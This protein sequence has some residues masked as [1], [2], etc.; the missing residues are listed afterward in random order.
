MIEGAVG[1]MLATRK[2]A[3]EAPAGTGKTEQIALI[4]GTV[5]GRWLVLTHTVA[6]VDAIRKRLKKY[7]VPDTKVHVETISAWSHRWARAF[8]ENSH[9]SPQWT[10]KENDWSTVQRAAADLVESGAVQSVLAASYDGVLVD[11]YQDCAE[12]QHRLICALSRMMRC[13]VFGDPL[14]AIFGFTRTDRVVDW[15]TRTIPEFPLAGQLAT[16]HRWN[17]VNNE[18]L[19]AW[20]LSARPGIQAGTIDLTKRPNCVEWVR[21]ATGQPVT[22]L[23]QFCSVRSQPGQTMAVL[24]SSFDAVRRAKLAKT[25]GGTTVEPVSGRCE[26]DFYDSVRNTGGLKRVAAILD[27]ASSAFAGANAAAKRKRVESLVE[28]PGRQRI[29]ASPAE[30]A[31]CAVASDASLRNVFDALECIEGEGGVTV[32]R[33]ELVYGIKASLRLCVENPGLSLEDATWQVANT[34]RERGRIVRNRSVG[35]TL[36]VKGLE[37]DHVVITPDACRTRLEWYVALTRAT[38]SVRVLSPNSSFTVG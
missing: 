30:I 31:L 33:P 12:S 34:R 35:S 27:F 18:E 9:L 21:C 5:P 36:L 24:D 16:P 2:G 19:G 29:S 14:Q 37:F 28:N 10:A 20:L 38:R 3:I 22:D 4:A 13:Y 1:Q 11:E 8:P 32:T 15:Y 6:G 17:A 26:R 7:S 23:G 25:I